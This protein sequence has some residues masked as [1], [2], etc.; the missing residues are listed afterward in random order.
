MVLQTNDYFG[1]KHIFAVLGPFAVQHRRRNWWLAI[2]SW[3]QTPVLAA[4]VHQQEMMKLFLEEWV[5][6]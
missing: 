4:R 2:G 1:K 5:T 6:P 3:H